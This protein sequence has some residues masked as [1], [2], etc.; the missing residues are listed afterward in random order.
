M[1]ATRLTKHVFQWYFDLAQNQMKNWK[2]FVPKIYRLNE[3]DFRNIIQ[4]L[5]S[6]T[7]VLNTK[8]N[9]NGKMIYSTTVI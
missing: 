1:P 2:Y 4:P 6:P 5:F 7:I 9:S 3:F 8:K